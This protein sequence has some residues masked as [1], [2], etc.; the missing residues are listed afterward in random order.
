MI[1]EGFSN[2]FYQSSSFLLLIWHRSY[3]GHASLR[4]LIGA[5]ASPLH[6]CVGL[7]AESLAL[8]RASRCAAAIFGFIHRPRPERTIPF[9]RVLGWLKSFD[10]LHPFQTEF[11]TI[12]PHPVE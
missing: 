3:P 11:R 2:W 7:V 12:D 4:S 1:N 9:G 10:T 8:F 6:T 5:Y